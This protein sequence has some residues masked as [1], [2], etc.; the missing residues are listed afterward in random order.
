M[1]STER[2]WARALVFGSL[3]AGAAAHVNPTAPT[4]VHGTAQ[5]TRPDPNSLNVTTSPNAIIN[6]RG[7]SIDSGETTRFIQPSST[8]AVLN[9]VTGADPSSI[10]GRLL[11]NG[12][13]FLVNPHGIVVGEDAVVDTAGLVASTLGISDADFLAGRYRFD[14]G[15]EAGDIVNQGLVKA[16]AD[17]VFL[18]APGIENSGIVRTDGGD[19]VLAAGRK[20][21]LTS[22]DL[23]GVRVEV[24]APEDEALNLGELIAERGAVGA[25]AGSLRSTGTVE[26]NAVTVDETGTIRLVASA[27]LTLEAGSRV[28]L[29][30][31][32]IDASGPTGG[33]EVLVGGDVSGEGPVPTAESTYVSSD[34]AVSADALDDGDGGK[35]VAFAEGFANLR[36]RL[37]ARGGPNGGDG[38]FVETSGL[39]SFVI[40]RTPDTT[41]PGGDGGHWLIDPYDIEIVAGSVDTGISKELDCSEPNTTQCFTSTGDSA[42]LGIELITQALSSNDQ[43]VT[44]QTGA[45]GTQGGDITLSVPI[46]LGSTSGTNN[47]LTLDAHRHIIINAE[48]T[49]SAGGDGLHL[50]LKAGEEVR[51]FKDVTV[52]GGSLWT[53]TRED[54]GLPVVVVIDG[55]AKLTLNGIPWTGNKYSISVGREGTGTLNIENGAEVTTR[56]LSIAE[57]ADSQGTVTVTGSGSKLATHGDGYHFVEVGGKGTGTLNVYNGGLVETL[58]LLIAASDMDATEPLGI[59]T[60]RVRGVDDEVRSRIIVSPAN[61]GHTGNDFGALA[62]VVEV[63][64]YTG[65]GHLEIREGGLL[66]VQDGKKPD[67]TDTH[68]PHLNLARHQDS[69]GTVLVDGAGSSLEVIQEAQAVYD[70]PNV[71]PG[72]EALLAWRG[73]GTTTVRNGGTLRVQGDQAVA[74]VSYDATFSE[75]ED[76]DTGPIDQPSVVRI[77]SGGRMEIDGAGATLV[78]GDGIIRDGDGGTGAVGKVTVTGAGSSLVTKGTD[79]RIQVGDEGKGTLN[80][81]DGG[82]VETLAFV[83]A[84]SKTGTGTVLIR[85]VTDADGVEDDEARSRI[86]TKGT[87]NYIEVGDEGTGTLEVLEGGLVETLSFVVARSGTGEVLISGVTDDG[88]RSR[89]IVSPANGRRSDDSDFANLAGFVRVGR[90]TGSD[91]IVEI[92]E[93]GLLRVLDSEGTHGPML[94]MARHKGSVG[95]VSIDGAGS[96]FE[97]IQKGPAVD[98]DLYVPPGPRVLLGWRG[99]GSTTVSNG[100][101]LRVQGEKA[102]V[103]VSQDEVWDKIPDP[104]ND[105][106]YQRSVVH[107]A[108]GGSMEIDG[109]DARLIIGLRGPSADGEVTVTGAGSSLVLTGAGNRLVVGAD[110]AT[111]TLNVFGGGD[112]QY[113]A[114]EIGPNGVVNLSLPQDPAPAPPEDPT[115]AP[116]QDP[117]PAPPQDP[118]PAPPQDPDPT[119]PEDPDPTPPE[120][121]APA[122]PQDPAPP[123]DSSPPPPEEVT[124]AVDAV[125]DDVLSLV[126]VTPEPA[127]VTLQIEAPEE[128]REPARQEEGAETGEDTGE[129]EE[130]REDSRPADRAG[131]SFEEEPEELPM[132]PA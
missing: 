58:Y 37:S 81:L 113:G 123:E 53:G 33:G 125:I 30:G 39:E 28:G 7:F 10:L 109:A 97:F 85:G 6:W 55:G 31:A 118:D 84:D 119:P 19:L 62:G 66:R 132:C 48:V 1:A 108:S 21:T 91:G 14:A 105:P 68:G 94:V 70:N 40:T 49:D 90:N 41:A 87:G 44:V 63:A 16:G 35:V 34:S 60:V 127:E 27:D 61:G 83:V 126:K 86:I 128:G 69:V 103:S 121:P 124:D 122:P 98:D 71:S 36:G 38:G 88:V 56:S 51:V 120:D 116:P 8:S 18:I 29:A 5:L 15:P 107:I 42:K 26:A 117:D 102:S 67:D 72:P 75:L 129:G 131:E 9:R 101:A 65:A 64:R 73:A 20:V 95:A 2:R 59:G 78:I 80:V 25:F 130:G 82:L 50:V 76:P 24:Q 43:S 12:R 74:R 106:I 93:G 114:L 79:N 115:P 112:L 89:I 17:G 104:D 96:S 3:L 100:G 52:L 46:D 32:Q 47:T 11:S 92:R 22:L 110:G 23:D 57:G 13:V 99:Q 77:E 4:V 111:G 45:G 54:G